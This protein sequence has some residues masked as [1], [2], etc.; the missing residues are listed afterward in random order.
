MKSA[1]LAAAALFLALSAA[2]G[3]AAQSLQ[4]AG[5]SGVVSGSCA[6]PL[7]LSY[8]LGFPL[9]EVAAEPLQASFVRAE[10][11]Y[12]EFTLAAEARVVLRSA[13]AAPE[14]DP[15]LT[16]YDAAGAILGSDDD[17]AGGYDAYLDLTL[18]AGRYCAQLRPL[19]GDRGAPEAVTLSI[20]AGEGAEAIAGAAPRP[21]PEPAGDLCGDPALIGTIGFDLAPGLGLIGLPARVEPG[22]RRDFPLTVA[23]PMELQ[24]DARSA[25]FDTVLKLADA[26]GTIIAENDDGPEMGTDSRFALAL[27]PGQYCLSLAGFD[28]AG[29]RADIALNDRPDIPVLTPL[30][31]AC[32]DPALTSELGIA[33]APG[34]GD[35]LTSGRIVPGGRGDWRFDVA[36]DMELQF[37]ARSPEL[38]TM[39]SLTDG[40]GTLIAEND[41]GPLGT[42]SRLVLSLSPGSY[43]LAVSGY[44]GSGGGYEIAVTDTPSPDATFPDPG[45][46]PVCSR[47]EFTADL[48]PALAPGFGALALAADLPPG[49]RQ[50][51]RLTAAAP[52]ALRIDA[53]SAAFDTTLSLAGADGAW[54]ADNDDGPSG[55]T[56]SRIDIA[57][58]AGDYCLSLEGF[59]GGGGAAELVIAERGAAELAADAVA[60]GE[61][62]PGPDSGVAI[63]DLGAL[64]DRLATTAI[65]EART[66]WVSFTLETDATL[67]IDAVAMGGFALRLFDESGAL[68]G[69]EFSGGGIS[70]ARL[71]PALGAGR[72]FIAIAFDPWVA[73]RLRNLSIAR[74]GG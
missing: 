19:G 33:L 18:P 60:A 46:V 20:A 58:A 34:F 44:S 13:A 71:Q 10:P 40:A 53:T 25:E 5:R 65:E 15:F 38:D 6:Q 72:Y 50:D 2:S 24:A 51:W 12:L 63:E 3:A 11:V 28:G 16:L 52:L 67:R 49:A 57:L 14:T 47:P 17:S 61:A 56:D 41:D 21:A 62:I 45:A 29:G 39:L 64:G 66:K 43:C 22:A 37:D 70:P 30:A 31:L 55:G 48:G 74:G 36:A 69:E 35:Y 1:F 54:I 73:S 27:E 8:T 4:G 59:A 26:S 7:A 23:A 68:V 42:D 9:D 32:T